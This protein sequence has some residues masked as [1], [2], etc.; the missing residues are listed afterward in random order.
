MRQLLTS[1]ISVAL[2]IGLALTV[3]V[4]TVPTTLAIAGCYACG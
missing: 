2:V 1:Q 3:F 4:L